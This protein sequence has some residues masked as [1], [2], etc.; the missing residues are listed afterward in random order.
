[1]TYSQEARASA[2]QPLPG[3]D[4][5]CRWRWH[6]PR[7]HW[8]WGSLVASGARETS[9]FRAREITYISEILI[10]LFAS[11][12]P[13]MWNNRLS[14]PPLPS[15]SLIQISFFTTFLWKLLGTVFP[16]YSFSLL[17][18]PSS[19][20][21]PANTPF[22]GLFLDIYSLAATSCTFFANIIALCHNCQ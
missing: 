19:P 1:M 9:S 2:F 17:P 3:T 7:R 18:S 16:S 10:I 6:L 14:S 4:K 12:S 8:K 20:W 15:A 5:V 22:L 13:N 21:F 11:P